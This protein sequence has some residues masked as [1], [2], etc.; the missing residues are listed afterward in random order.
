MPTFLT[1]DEYE[2]LLSTSLYWLYCQL[3]SWGEEHLKVYENMMKDSQS[4]WTRVTPLLIENI[5]VHLYLR[6]P[7]KGT[8]K[9]NK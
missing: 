6:K 9:G 7:S 5:W 8:K 2:Y 4:Q 1:G 3:A